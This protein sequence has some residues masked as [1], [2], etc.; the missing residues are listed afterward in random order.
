[1]IW[2]VKP[3]GPKLGGLMTQ[4]EHEGVYAVLRYDAFQGE[5]SQPEVAITVK[6]VVRSLDLAEAE[7][8]RLSALNAEKHVRYW[9]QYTRLFPQG[10][11]ASSQDG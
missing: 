9:W 6:E 8:A 5:N 7:V 10:K 2:N 4:K 11:S 1:M 3:S